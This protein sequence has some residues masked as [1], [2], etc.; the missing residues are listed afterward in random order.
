MTNYLTRLWLAQ[1]DTGNKP[2]DGRGIPLSVLARAKFDV[3]IATLST[4]LL[5]WKTA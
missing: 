5:I 2:V 4:A 3:E 1:K